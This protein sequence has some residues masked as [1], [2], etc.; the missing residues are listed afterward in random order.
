MIKNLDDL[1]YIS[2]DREKARFYPS[3]FNKPNIELYLKFKGV[4][5]TNPPKWSDTL[6]WGA[7]NGVEEQMLKILKMN[8]IVAE[9][10]NQKE[11][12]GFKMIREGIEIGGYTDARTIDGLPIEIKSIN[13]KNSFDIKK[14]ENGFP[15]ENY[16][17]Q[18]SI[19]MDY[20]GVDTGYL[21]ASTVDGLS[22]FWFE[23]KK[24]DDG[25]Y[26]CGN[27]IVD[28]Y[29]EYRRWAKLK[30]EYIDKD[31]EPKWT[32]YLYKRDVRTLDFR[33]EF[34]NKELSKSA[35]QEA[36]MG[37]KVIGAWEVQ[38]SP[39]KNLIIEKQ[40][41][42]LGYTLEELEIIKQKTEGY[43]SW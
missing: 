3:D 1:L 10:Y 2:E 20:L 34:E 33:K 30:T 9:D 21:F 12:G 39:Y 38:Y 6:K 27:V 32:Q 17:G 41:S 28:I 8:K 40:G 23:C 43:T 26:S 31:I 24:I 11:H 25:V 42:Q 19:Y 13:N 15:R 35:I 36:R 16:V 18:L 14:Y 7:G 5:E 37:R 4:K 29:K 22:T